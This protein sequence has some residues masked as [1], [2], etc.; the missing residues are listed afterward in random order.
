MDSVK[1]I[2]V[3]VLG[4][5]VT[6]QAVSAYLRQST[7][8][9][10]V[11]VDAAQWVV[12]SPGIPPRK[13][14]KTT[15]EIL[16]DNEFAYR[17]LHQKNPKLVMIGVTGTN[18]KTTVVSAL[19]HALGVRAYGN[20][21]RPLIQDVDTIDVSK[22][23]VIEL[24]SYQLVTTTTMRFTI[25]VIMNIEPD[26]YDWHESYENYRDAKCR[27]STLSS[28]LYAPQAVWSHCAKD[29]CEWVNTDALTPQCLP[30]LTARHDQH[31]AA[32]IQAI[33]QRLGQAPAYVQQKMA[34]F[35]RPPFRYETIFCS[36][37]LCIINDSKAT[38][39]AATEAALASV[40]G[41]PVLLILCGQAKSDYT[42]DFMNRVTERCDWVYAA[43]GLSRNRHQFPV[44]SQGAIQFFDTLY[45]ATCAALMQCVKGIILF[46]PSAASFDEF[47]N[48]EARG[49]A[50]TT[51][52]DHIQTMA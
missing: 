15:A 51:Y 38:N 41:G 5:G 39:M 34:T 22:P 11:T 35:E 42:M 45:D 10:Q 29:H 43:G 12:V 24:S 30:P 50:F 28:V 48:Y 49:K 23:I 40:V 8:Y 9:E 44:S 21:G 2:P 52:V 46:S 37:D 6:G 16:S 17:I 18:G 20:I 4:D 14:P 27:L 13:W 7:S 26:H 25:G 32:L 47:T 3:A 19:A 36:E 33:L 1:P 31:N